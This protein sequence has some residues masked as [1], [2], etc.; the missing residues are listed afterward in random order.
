MVHS[1]LG[2]R[3]I[4]ALLLTSLGALI[5]ADSDTLPDFFTNLPIPSQGETDPDDDDDDD[6]NIAIIRNSFQASQSP[7]IRIDPNY[8]PRKPSNGVVKLILEALLKFDSVSAKTLA[9]ETNIQYAS[10]IESLEWLGYRQYIEYLAGD[11]KVTIRLTTS[12][13]AF[14]MKLCNN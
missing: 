9:E 8:K 3:K 10:L 7:I 14:A 13:R 2:E 11:H 5:V 1:L 6:Q 4:Y 12:G